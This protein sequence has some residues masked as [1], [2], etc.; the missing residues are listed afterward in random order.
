MAAASVTLYGQPGYGGRESTSVRQSERGTEITT[1]PFRISRR[2]KSPR[3]R[4]PTFA[5]TTAPPPLDSSHSASASAD[6]SALS[7]PG[8]DAS[9]TPPRRITGKR[10]GAPPLWPPPRLERPVTAGNGLGHTL[11]ADMDAPRQEGEP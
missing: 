8:A 9:A 3:P 7:N 10:A 2:A 5:L 1:S 6:A 4:E 11:V